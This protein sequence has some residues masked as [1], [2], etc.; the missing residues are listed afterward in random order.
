LHGVIGLPF[1]LVLAGLGSA[2]YLYMMRP[3][4]PELIQQKFAALYDIMVRKYLFDE[5]YQA[6]FMRGSRGLG[7]RAVEIRR[8]GL[9]RRSD[10]ERHG[11]TGGLVRRHHPACADRL[12]ISPMRLP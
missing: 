5:I 7:H 11:T 1:I 6:V 12:S 10:G 2:F 3:D 9:D 4:L 8:R